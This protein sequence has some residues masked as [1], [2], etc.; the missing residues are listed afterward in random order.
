MNTGRNLQGAAGT[1]CR[2]R[3]LLSAPPPNRPGSGLYPS[4]GGSSIPDSTGIGRRRLK[5]LSSWSESPAGRGGSSLARLV[6]LVDAPS[7]SWVLRNVWLF[8][9]VFFYIQS[10]CKARKVPQRLCVCAS[11]GQMYRVMMLLLDLNS[12]CCIIPVYIVRTKCRC[13]LGT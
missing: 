6:C 3:P 12:V 8:F 9:V 5:G 4:G 2:L 1:N 10:C 11:C 7:T 13:L